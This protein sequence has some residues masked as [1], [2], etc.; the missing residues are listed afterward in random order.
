M[1][2]K[3]SMLLRSCSMRYA[4]FKGY[5]PRFIVHHASRDSTASV[6]DL[7]FNAFQMAKV[8][9]NIEIGLSSLH[10]FLPIIIITR[11]KGMCAAYCQFL[12]SMLA[13]VVQHC[14]VS[15]ATL[16]RKLCSIAA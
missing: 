6:G 4:Q 7:R 12:R 3:G 14:C 5:L 13:Q 16:L 11:K 10:L 15:C 2:F 1:T 9:K 8:I